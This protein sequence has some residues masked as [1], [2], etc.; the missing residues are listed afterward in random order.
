M[1][2]YEE[3]FDLRANS[4]LRNK[5]SVACAK[6]AQ[7]L[8]DGGAPTA[9]EVAWASAVLIN[10]LAQADKIF[11]YVLAAN[12]AATVSQILAATDA[13]IQSNVDAAVA[14]LIAGGITS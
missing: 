8:L 7:E 6:R 3:L 2:T 11:I 4:E 13:A 1:A 14:A 10:P 9:D 5:V 12:S